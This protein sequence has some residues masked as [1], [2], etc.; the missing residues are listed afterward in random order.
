MLLQRIAPELVAGYMR[1][2][3]ASAG[4]SATATDPTAAFNATFSLPDTIRES[5]ARQ[6]EL[7]LGGI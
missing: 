4:S 3:L 7:V 5:L 1:Y 2:Y 6:I